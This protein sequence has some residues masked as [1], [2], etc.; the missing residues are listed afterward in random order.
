M[1]PHR[2][3]INQSIPESGEIVVSDVELTHQLRRVFRFTPGNSVIV[4]DGSGFDFTCEIISFEKES[5]T[6]SVIEK[7]VNQ[8]NFKCEVFLFASL[9]KNSNYEWILEKCTELGVS[10]FI[11]VISERS[12]KKNLNYD[13]A[14]KII[15]EAVEQSGRGTLP[16]MYE[17]IPL[18]AV[19]EKYSMPFVAFHIDGEHFRQ[20]NDKFPMTNNKIGI[21]IGPE[22]GWSE[23]ELVLFKEKNVPIYSLGNQVLRAE[24]AAVAVSSLVLVSH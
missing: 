12:E 13:R 18:E 24:T 23:R 1:R 11:P 17:A 19:F 21:L 4:F 16:K 15:K 10:H 22:G 3:Y 7:K 20:G 5:V 2:F 9:I 14:R 6:F 8:G